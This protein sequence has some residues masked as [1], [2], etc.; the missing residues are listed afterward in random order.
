MKL[1]TTLMAFGVLVLS[2]VLGQDTSYVPNPTTL[3]LYYDFTGVHTPRPDSTQNISQ[4][5]AAIASQ[6]TAVTNGPLVLFTS[7]DIQIYSEDRSLI[8]Q[9]NTRTSPNTGFYEVTSLSHIGPALGYLAYIKKEE[10]LWENSAMDMLAHIRTLRALNA[11][12]LV[13][14]GEEI[15]PSSH[16]L[17]RLDNPAWAPNKE[18]IKNMF[19]YGYAMSGTFLQKVLNGDIELTN[20][21]VRKYFLSN[22]EPMSDD[23]PISFNHVMIATFQLEGLSEFHRLYRNLSQHDVDWANARILIRSPV[24]NNF[25]GGVSTWTNWTINALNLLAGR[26]EDSSFVIKPDRMLVVPY[27]TPPDT[28]LGNDGKMTPAAYGYFSGIVFGALYSQTFTANQVFS[29]VES[30]DR[31][32]RPG[33]HGD[34]G[35]STADDIDHFV[36]RLK[37]SFSVKTELLSN[38]IGFWMPNE[39]ESKGYDVSRIQIPGLNAGMPNDMEYPANNPVIPE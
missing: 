30:L 24:G 11:V 19:D 35:V 5:I 39:V 10:G 29:D 14:E 2:N 32:I 18:R 7:E 22:L 15:T 20:E 3:E 37:Y 1:K 25:G 8:A 6:D 4:K 36:E 33:M 12:P 38:T 28:I 31:P 27:M 17:D 23:F 34:Y 9:T 13:Q 16:W 21:N 26:N